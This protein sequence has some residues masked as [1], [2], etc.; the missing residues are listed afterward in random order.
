MD[1]LSFYI[2]KVIGK[3]N[4][5]DIYSHTGDL[6]IPVS[7]I[8]TYDHIIL[9][10]ENGIILNGD[11]VTDNVSDF[12]SDFT[13]HHKMIDETV[14]Q[15][16]EIFGEIRIT[17]KIPLAQLRK[18]AIPTILA[19]SDSKYLLPLFAALQA[20][21]DYTYRHNIAVAALSNLIGN[22][23]KLGKQELLQLTTAALLH[24][25]GKMFIP[26]EILNKPGKFTT[27]EFNTMKK[28]TIYGYEILKGTIGINHRQALV[29]LQHHERMDGSGYPLG[30]RKE[31]IDLFSR[32]VSVADVFHAMTS[33]RVYR[34]HSPFYE[35]LSE[36]GRNM[37]STLDPVITKLFI[38]KTMNSLIGYSVLLTDGR[39]G[40]I[41]LIHRNDPTRP[42]IQLGN[43]FLDMSKDLSICI[44]QIVS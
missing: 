29:A 40:R 39:V 23:M 18:E 17:K 32:I 36:M 1:K 35:V 44:E 16:S 4:R 25:V 43:E 3:R 38:E 2:Q 5:K 20:K 13:Q 10:E 37:F 34:N 33:N 8:I 21:D 26:E 19:A 6:L 28:H 12:Q 22:W 9:L 11:E 31:N 24:D 14:K 41:L 42:L 30:I 15:V 27:E 7:T